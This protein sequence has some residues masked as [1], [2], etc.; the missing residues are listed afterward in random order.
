MM[1][2]DPG[3]LGLMSV[4]LAC[5]SLKNCLVC[6]ARESSIINNA[7]SREVCFTSGGSTCYLGSALASVVLLIS[8]CYNEVARCQCAKEWFQQLMGMF[9]MKSLNHLT[10]DRERALIGCVLLGVHEGRL[11]V[12]PI[13]LASYM[14]P[15]NVLS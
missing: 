6:V 8:V 11:S 4:C 1:T 2:R 14:C 7:G 9:T 13:A 10:L 15:L 12:K 3:W 5:L